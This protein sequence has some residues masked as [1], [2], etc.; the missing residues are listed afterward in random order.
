MYSRSIYCSCS[1]CPSRW[2]SPRGRTCTCST[3]LGGAIGTQQSG[4][5]TYNRSTGLVSSMDERFDAMNGRMND[6]DRRFNQIDEALAAIPS[7]LG[8]QWLASLYLSLKN[9]GW[10]MSWKKF[11][12][13]FSGYLLCSGYF[14]LVICFKLFY[15]AFLIILSILEQKGGDFFL[16]IFVNIND[17]CIWSCD[18]LSRFLQGLKFR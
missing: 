15:S 2:W 16:L 8:N 10:L 18:M 14:F 6:F 4:C 5:S 13:L 11:W 17:K 1:C 9:C 3:S 7:C 12:T